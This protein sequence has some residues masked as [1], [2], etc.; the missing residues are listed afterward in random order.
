MHSAVPMYPS[1][2]HTST[3]VLLL[4][5]SCTQT[6]HV[7][8]CPT[9]V[10][11]G[12]F[13]CIQQYPCIFQSYIRLLRYFYL[14]SAGSMYP[15][16]PPMSTQVLLLAYSS[17]LQSYIRLLRYFYLHSAGYRYPSVLPTSSQ[18]ILL[19]FSSTQVSFSPKYVYSGFYLH[20]AVPRVSFSPTY[21]YSGTFT[22][23][24]IPWTNL[25]M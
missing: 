24:Q 13:T 17:I 16:V 5:F 14:H 22:C 21:A 1:V 6:T 9:Y 18:V 2:L 3:Q 4:A 12:T 7:S 15:S 11:S 10:Y 8:F 19:A 20:S 25:T 23:I